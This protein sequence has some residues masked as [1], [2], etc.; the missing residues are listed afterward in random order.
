MRKQ[1]SG[2][3]A[4]L[5]DVVP[6]VL[7][8]ASGADDMTLA[9]HNRHAL[10]ASMVQR[11]Q[12]YELL[13]AGGR[14]YRPR[15]YGDPQPDGRWNGW[16]IFFPLTGGEAIAPPHAETTQMTWTALTAWAA[17]LTPVYVQGALERALTVALQTPAPISQLAVAEYE[18]LQD[19]ERLETEA[20]VQR[21]AA[22]LDE[23]AADTARH[24]A[25]RIRQQ[26]F[27]TESTLAAVE[28]ATAKVDAAIHEEAARD[29]REAAAEAAQRRR[30]A[31][32]RAALPGN[33]TT[34]KKVTKKR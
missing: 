20:D 11:I 25:D 30:S 15:A 26:R 34:K 3:A 27:A 31:K 7:V 10:E 21:T 14:W 13:E 33:R 19:A 29:A 9:R 17:G 22:D 28:E 32:T 6:L 16:L 4:P 12:Q 5:I 18:A 1:Q 24:E 2:A 8:D 23:V